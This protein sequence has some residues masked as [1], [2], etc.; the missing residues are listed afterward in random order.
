MRDLNKA[1]KKFLVKWASNNPV[2]LTSTYSPV[3]QMDYEEYEKLEAMNDHETL[4]QNA[5][6]YLN[7]LHVS[8]DVPTQKYTIKEE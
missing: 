5:N 8:Y 6:R 1:Q 4:Y 7:D 3:D 2:T